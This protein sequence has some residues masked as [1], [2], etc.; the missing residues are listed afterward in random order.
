MTG[1]HV[2]ADLV[3]FAVTAAAIFGAYR[4][5]DCS[6]YERGYIQTS[7]VRGERVEV[8]NGSKWVPWIQPETKP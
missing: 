1:R 7:R 2:A 5:D 3:L 6:A 4:C 8:C